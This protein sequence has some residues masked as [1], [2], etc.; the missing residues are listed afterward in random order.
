MHSSV[1]A[2]ARLPRTGQFAG[3]WRG[4]AAD[5]HCVLAVGESIRHEI[6]AGRGR[7]IHEALT[8]GATWTET[9]D[10]L[11]RTP[12]EVRD[13]LRNY[14]DEQPDLYPGADR[15]VTVTALIDLG[16]DKRAPTAQADR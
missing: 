4:T 16:D 7:H 14:A 9:A 5:A 1:L 10:A 11:G 6:Q 8:L 15:R 13:E 3:I 2:N 12:N